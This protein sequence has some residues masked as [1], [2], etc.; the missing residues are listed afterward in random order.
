MA[1]SDVGESSQDAILV[2]VMGQTG[3]GKSNFINKATGGS[4]G[5]GHSL[6][7]CARS[8]S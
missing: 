6:E 8:S 5:V 2:A 4:L 3:T 1:T 7:S